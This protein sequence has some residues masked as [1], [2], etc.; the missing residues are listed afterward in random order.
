MWRGMRRA[1]RMQRM[2][3][4]PVSAAIRKDILENTGMATSEATLVVSCSELLP[5][6]SK[7]KLVWGKGIKAPNGVASDRE[8]SFQY[9][10][11]A[12]FAAEMSCER[13]KA[14]APC[15]PMSIIALSFNAPVVG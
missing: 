13:E 5:A 14:G 9:K 15:S 3:A 10:V 1:G 12:P 11:R 7:M 4:R 6:G 8:E 2:P